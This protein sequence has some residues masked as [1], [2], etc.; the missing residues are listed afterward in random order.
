MEKRGTP[1]G[2]RHSASSSP[3]GRVQAEKSTTEEG[4]MKT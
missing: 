1:S 4:E 3:E 2:C